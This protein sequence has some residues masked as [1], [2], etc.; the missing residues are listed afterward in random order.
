MWTHAIGCHSDEQGLVKTSLK[1][2]LNIYV[3]NGLQSDLP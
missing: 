2:N 3:Y 1:I